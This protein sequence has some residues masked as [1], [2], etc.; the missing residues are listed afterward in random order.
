M[1][2]KPFFVKSGAILVAL[3]IYYITT[4][5]RLA[6]WKV[7]KKSNKKWPK[8]ALLH[9]VKSEAILVA[10]VSGAVPGFL[11]R[12]KIASYWHGSSFKSALTHCSKPK[13]TILIVKEDNDKVAKHRT[14][15]LVPQ[16]SL[17]LDQASIF[18]RGRIQIVLDEEVS[19][20][21]FKI[22]MG[23]IFCIFASTA[24]WKKNRKNMHFLCTLLSK[25][26]TITSIKDFCNLSVLN[27]SSARN[28]FWFWVMFANFFQ[29]PS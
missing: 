14:C 20:T 1:T 8:K 2:Q 6:N 29:L 13:P 9:F 11:F 3:V 4:L 22:G 27:E 5:L 18:S 19:G 21:K 26:L 23:Q 16:K 10:L 7:S 15:C 28:Q 12:L 25:N 17:F 24:S